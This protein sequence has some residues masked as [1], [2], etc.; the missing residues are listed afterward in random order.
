MRPRANFLSS[1]KTCGVSHLDNIPWSESLSHPSTLSVHPFHSPL[2]RQ[3]W[4]SWARWRSCWRRRRWC[5]RRCWWRC[6]CSCARSARRRSTRSSST[7]KKRSRRQT[8]KIHF[9]RYSRGKSIVNCIL[10]YIHVIVRVTRLMHLLLGLVSYYAEKL[11]P[12]GSLW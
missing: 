8:G 3:P 9:K 6:C 2:L 12:I 10:V 7:G 4:C 5:W 1:L 11:A